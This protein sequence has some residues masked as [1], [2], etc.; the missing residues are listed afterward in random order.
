LPNV[1]NGESFVD[2]IRNLALQYTTRRKW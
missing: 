2:S 1:T